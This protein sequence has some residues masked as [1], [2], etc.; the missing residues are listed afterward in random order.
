MPYQQ[1]TISVTHKVC[2]K[3]QTAGNGGA[4]AK[5]CNAAAGLVGRAQRERSGGPM[6]ALCPLPMEPPLPT[7]HALPLTLPNVLIGNLLAGQDTID[8]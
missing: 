4:L 7:G 3:A 1:I 5:G 6:A 8:E 2:G